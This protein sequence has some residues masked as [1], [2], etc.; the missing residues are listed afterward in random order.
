MFRHTN[1]FLH[2]LDVSKQ[3]IPD[4]WRNSSP[5]SSMKK[6]QQHPSLWLMIAIFLLASCSKENVLSY[7]PQVANQEVTFSLFEK[8]ISD[9]D[10]RADDNKSAKSLKNCKSISELEVALFPEDSRQDTVFIVRQDSA[11]KDF[12]QVKLYVPAGTYKMVAVAATTISPQ[13]GNRININSVNEVTFP[14]NVV[15][16]MFYTL[17]S[18]TI[19]SGKSNQS[20][21]CSLQRG[22]SMLELNCQEPTRP[23]NLKTFS[24]TI[25]G[26]CGNV[27]NPTTGHCLKKSNIT[28]TYTLSG[29]QYKNS[30]F[31]F[32]IYMFLGEDDVSD[33]KLSTKAIDLDGKEMKSLSFDNIRLVKG[34]VTTYK[35]PFF[36]NNTNM[37]FTIDSETIQDSGYGKEFE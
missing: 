8:T 17:E 2:Q 9:I 31:V 34:K 11:A 19:E 4:I 35:G 25:T 21:D 6:K 33:I 26:N 22:V 5:T 14:Y 12:G 18:I 16:D 23:R 24:Y 28:N 30:H 20:F 36:T 32:K 37:T 1:I 27:F 13:K 3:I 10:S 15:K 29:N 7:S